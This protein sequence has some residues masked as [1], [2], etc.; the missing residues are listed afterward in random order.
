MKKD[1]IRSRA[2]TLIELLVVIAIIALL[3]G[4]LLPALGKARSSARRTV[5]ISNL[6]QYGVGAASYAT[7][8]QDKIPSYSWERG[9]YTSRYGDLQTSPDNITATMYQAID[10]I[11]R[12]T[13]RDNFPVLTELYPHRRYTHLVMLDYIGST[14][15]TQ[16]VACPEDRT[17]L[18]WQEDP[19]DLSEMPE[20]RGP[21]VRAMWPYSS[22]YQAV[23]ASWAEDSGVW[24]S[25]EGTTVQQYSQDYN[26]MGVGSKPL[27]RRKLS[28]VVF[29]GMKVFMFEFHDRHT[30]RSGVFYA[31]PQAKSSQ[32][33]FD[34]SVFARKTGDSNEGFRPNQAT[35]RRATDILYR[36]TDLTFEPDPLWDVVAGDNLKGHYR[37]T[38]GGLK[39]VDYGGS[40][41]D[42]GQ[43]PTNP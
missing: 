17:L 26:L 42:T 28:Q 5:C 34:G 38:R 14:L 23:P 43:G 8:S 32:L 16:M 1:S 4:I 2:F 10:I 19:L 39:G 24:G 37:W 12:R 13:G 33:F 18:R 27:G 9:N 22:T 20:W 6:K 3:I 36:I 7:D 29:A 21:A 31:Y 41:I 35:Q 11:R 30:A 40:E 15:P 25:D